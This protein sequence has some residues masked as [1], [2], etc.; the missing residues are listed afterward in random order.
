MSRSMARASVSEKSSRKA[1]AIPA[2]TVKRRRV[3]RCEANTNS[4]FCL[5]SSS[6]HRFEAERREMRSDNCKHS[7][8]RI[9]FFHLLSARLLGWRIF[10]REIKINF[11]R[12]SHRGEVHRVGPREIVATFERRAASAGE[13]SSLEAGCALAVFVA[14]EKSS[15]AR[16]F[17]CVFEKSEH[18]S[19]RM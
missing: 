10:K 9:S 2:H 1:A 6:F 12:L 18:T 3:A 17:V 5:I 7:F 15:Q 8:G 13:K 14:E 11:R 16:N 19:E 4:R